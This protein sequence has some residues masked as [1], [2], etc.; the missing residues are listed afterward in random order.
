MSDGKLTADGDEASEAA[1]ERRRF[2]QGVGAMA[3][4]AAG[5]GTGTAAAQQNETDEQGDGEETGEGGPSPA[6]A[7]L[8]DLPTNWGRW[9]DDDELGALNLLGASEMAAGMQAALQGG[10]DNVERFTLQT[11]ITGNAVD[12][13]I[14]EGEF[15][16][17]DTGD[18][19]F[20]GRMPARRDNEADWRDADSYAGLRFADDKFV[21]P[22]FL[23]GT[24]HADALGH[25]FFADE[26]VNG[27]G[28]VDQADE[29]LYNG[30]MAETTASTRS[31]EYGVPGLTDTDGDG[32]DEAG[33]IDEVH[34]LERA[35]ITHAANAGIQGRGVLLDVGRHLGDDNGWLPLN[36]GITLEDLQATAEA[37]GVEIR[38][39]DI[40]LIRTGAIERVRDPDA[41][42]HAQGEPGLTYSDQ[43]VEW[44]A[45]L[46]IPYIAADNLPVEKAQHEVTEDDLNE[47]RED[48]AGTYVL[49]LHGAFLRN[50]GV[51]LNEVLDLSDLAA[52]SADDGVY[53]FLFTAAPLN[54]EGATGAPI[55][56]VVTKSTV[57]STGNS[58]NG[59]SGGGNEGTSDEEA[60][61]GTETQ[62]ETEDDD[63]EETQGGLGPGFG[64]MGGLAGLAGAVGAKRFLSGDEE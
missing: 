43:L 63:A 58:D 32:T 38:E 40:L 29:Q 1:I 31:Y 4:L 15:P 60:G 14:G 30:F 26:D 56:P 5:G 16:T 41:A 62:P 13:L 39:R 35:D 8:G 21:A 50:L 61:S 24:S 20:P 17:T 12:A 11:P 22:L 45:D 18:P 52:A 44:V 54:V 55:N 48:L 59:G 2:V 27:D 3:A 28:V 6:G 34:M 64:V 49:P 46:D 47:G 33:S 23:Q 36:Y 19:A 57:A 25:G 53:T 51:T 7:L 42:W 9:G 37:Q 10:D